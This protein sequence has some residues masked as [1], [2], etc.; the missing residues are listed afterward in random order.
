MASLRLN[1]QSEINLMSNHNVVEI[2]LQLKSA[3]VHGKNCIRVR[4]PSVPHF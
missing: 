3:K 1:L 2:L 4:P